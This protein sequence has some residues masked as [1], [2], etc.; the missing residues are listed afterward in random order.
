MG[1]TYKKKKKKKMKSTPYPKKMFSFLCPLQNSNERKSFDGH[2]FDATNI[3]S[4][5]LNAKQKLHCSRY[6]EEF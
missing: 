3:C 1:D 6:P 4:G 5:L 2:Q